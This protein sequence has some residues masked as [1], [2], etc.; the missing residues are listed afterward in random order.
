MNSQ[1][2]KGIDGAGSQEIFRP[3]SPMAGEEWTEEAF[4]IIA[5]WPAGGKVLDKDNVAFNSPETVRALVFYK[6][7]YRYTPT[8]S[9]NWG[10]TETMNAFVS[11]SVAMDLLLGGP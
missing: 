7:L 3:E 9:E 8:G 5:L 10:Y 11:G 4:R 2:F 6:S 1:G